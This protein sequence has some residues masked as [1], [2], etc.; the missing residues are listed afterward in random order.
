MRW[1]CRRI[2]VSPRSRQVL[3]LEN[4]WIRQLSAGGEQ[5]ADQVELGRDRRAEPGADEAAIG[6]VIAVVGVDDRV[7]DLLSSSA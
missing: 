4:S 6:G 2:A 5:L 7:D 1:R 3:E